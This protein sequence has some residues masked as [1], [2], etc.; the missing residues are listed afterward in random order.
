MKYP[1]KIRCTMSAPTWMATLV[2]IVPVVSSAF[3]HP[4]SGAPLDRERPL[5]ALPQSVNTQAGLAVVVGTTD[6]RFEAALV[7]VAQTC[8][9]RDGVNH[10]SKRRDNHDALVRHALADD[11]RLLVHGLAFDDDAVETARRYL[12]ENGLCGIV[13]VEKADTLRRLPYAENLVNLLVADLD[14]LGEEAP[15]REEI[16]RVLAPGGTACLKWRGKWQQTLKPRPDGMDVWTHLNHGADGNPASTDRLVANPHRLRWI[17]SEVMGW[18]MFSVRATERR[19]FLFWDTLIQW[20]D[21]RPDMLKIEARD[22]F[23]GVL[24]WQEYYPFPVNERTRPVAVDERI[25]MLSGKHAIAIDATDGKVLHTF[26]ECETPYDTVWADGVLLCRNDHAVYAFDAASGKLLW[27][28]NTQEHPEVMAR[29]GKRRKGHFEPGWRRQLLVVGDGHVY[30]ADHSPGTDGETSAR[31]VGLDIRTGNER[32]YADGEQVGELPHPC[33][34]H[35][36]VLALTNENGYAGIPTGKRGRAWVVPVQGWKESRRYRFGP[37]SGIGINGY[38]ATDD[39]IWI[40]DRQK[41][42]LGEEPFASLEEKPF[43]GWIGVDPM[44]GDV[45]KRIY[46]G[47]KESWSSRC[48]ADVAVPGRI[49]AD[50]MEIVDLKTGDFANFRT[51]RGQCGTGHIFANGLTYTSPHRC[52]SCY[53]MLRGATALCGESDR[54]TP[55]PDRSRLERGPAYGQIPQP[56]YPKQSDIQNPA[57]WPTY[58]HNPLRTNST[59]MKLP[60]GLRL[61]W[62]AEFGERASTPVAAGGQLFVAVINQGRLCALDAQTGRAAW[63]FVAGSRIDTPPTIHGPLCLFGCHDGA[64]YCLTG[65]G[66]CARMALRCR[67][68]GSPDCRL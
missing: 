39:L 32:W 6:G 56:K 65:G 12:E 1:A 30:F 18:G 13:S 15:P 67:P 33:F 24:L 54:G 17:A 58:R 64:I 45:E 44:T 43:K 46:Y 52:V 29:Y 41:Q 55:I 31:V 35:D 53:P 20:V 49:F 23:S 59:P 42:R 48:Y 16:D 8:S 25:Y 40:K 61:L 21:P 60:R 22:A 50:N 57:E 34:Y 26:K 28:H 9:V 10:E 19:V 37:F 38:L 68:G 14:A 27:T 66:R 4:A 36:G 3:F 11:R 2:L 7:R 63:S 62:T 5:A 47:S 51:A